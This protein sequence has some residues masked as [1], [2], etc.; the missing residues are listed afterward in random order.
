MT[1]EQKYNQAVESLVDWVERCQQS[2][3]TDPTCLLILDAAIDLS[4]QVMG[5]EKAMEAVD[6]MMREKIMEYDRCDGDEGLER[7]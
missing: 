2:G 1:E 3:N 5:R 7:N 6:A 4:F